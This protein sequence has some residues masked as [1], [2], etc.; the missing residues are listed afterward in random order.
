MT[1]PKWNDERTEKLV[2]IVGDESPVTQE[3]VATAAEE[4]ETT[5]KSVAAK[6]RKMEYVVESVTA[7]A[8]RT[9][10]EKEEEV[11]KDFVTTNS[12]QFTYAQIAENFS[13]GKF[14]AR[15][16]QGKILSLQLTEHVKPTPK[17]E[18]VRT[19]SDDEEATIVSLAKEGKFI[20]EIAEAISR[21]VNQ[22]RG[23]ALSLV[24][25]GVLESIPQQRDSKGTAKVDP[26]AEID[27]TVMSVEE[28]AEKVGKTPR[29]IKTMLTRRGL[30][31]TNYDGAAKAAKAAEA[32]A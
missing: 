16:I 2:E 20:E 30:K 31:A 12:G 23:K 6:L 27:V 15:Q 1:L 19:F 8:T 4:L 14:N 22:V 17:P 9:F 28:I 13:G 11:L 29:G 10:S 3:T 24:K 7:T 5:S 26:F 25:S 21:E 32:N 18:V